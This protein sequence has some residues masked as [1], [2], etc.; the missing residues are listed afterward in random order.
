MNKTKKI[1]DCKTLQQNS[2]VWKLG[3]IPPPFP[4]KQKCLWCTCLLETFVYYDK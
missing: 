4:K 3:K 1:G 2:Q